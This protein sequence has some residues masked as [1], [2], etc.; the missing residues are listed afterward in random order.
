ME[1]VCR[2]AVIEQLDVVEIR[3]VLKGL[4]LLV[5]ESKEK[6]KMFSDLAIYNKTAKQEKISND[7]IEFQKQECEYIENLIYKIQSI[8]EDSSFPF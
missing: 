2:E 7:L 1:A 6:A 5:D 4:E 8:E 3:T